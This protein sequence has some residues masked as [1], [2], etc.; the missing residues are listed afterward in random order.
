[1]LNVETAGLCAV[2]VFAKGPLVVV[3]VWTISL[4]HSSV[5]RK[6]AVKRRTAARIEVL[7]EY[8]HKVLLLINPAMLSGTVYCTS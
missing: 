5:Q 7:W 6:P 1:M 3:S 4:V 2:N 8:C